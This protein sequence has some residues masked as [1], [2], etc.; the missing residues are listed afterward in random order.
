MAQRS[1]G[2][3]R[4]GESAS[5]RQA[6]KA[7]DFQMKLA[8]EQWQM[9][10]DIYGRQVAGAAGVTEGLEGL[11]GG[12]NVAYSEAKEANEAR[13]RE[14]LGISDTLVDQR[15]ADIQGAYRGREADMMQKLARQGLGGTTIAPTMT[16]GIE[17]EKQSA[18]D[19]SKQELAAQRIG[20]R[21]RREDEYPSSDI[22]MSLAS[23]FAQGGG[24]AG[25]GNVMK[26]LGSLRQG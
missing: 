12:Y 4:P 13:Y 22:I 6:R 3:Y 15:S 19:R 5:S 24:G 8:G 1:G 23:A 7:S 21:E 9:Q 16:A 17:R 11:V 18:L 20:V 26:A 14:M 25:A 2:V 10:K